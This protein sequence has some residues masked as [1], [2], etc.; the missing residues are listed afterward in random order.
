MKNTLLWR[1]LAAVFAFLLAAIIILT[2]LALDNAGTINNALNISTSVIVPSEGGEQT[3]TEYY[4]SE[5]G[6][7]NASN[8]A[9]LRAD[10]RA[11]NVAEMEEGAVLLKNDD[12][13]LPL[14]KGEIDNVSLFGRASVDPV[15][16]GNSAG[17]GGGE[18][19]WTDAL[20]EAGFTYN[21]TLAD[22]Y[23]NS[24]AKRERGTAG[25][26]YTIQIGE[27]PVSEYT[28]DVRASWEG[29]VAIVMISRAGGEDSELIMEMTDYSGRDAGKSQLAL[30]E[31][32]KDM[33]QLLQT[34]KQE[35]RISKIV[36]LI[37]SGW[38][39]E[40][41]WL[42][43]YGVDAA[44]WIGQPGSYG[45]AG[46]ANILKGDANPSGRLAD[47]YAENSLSSPAVINAGS[48]GTGEWTNI[49]EYRTQ[50]TDAVNNESYYVVQAEGIYIGYKYYETRYEDQILGQ[51]NA[52]SSKGSSDGSAWNWADEV[53]FPFGYGLSYTTFEQTLDSVTVGE[54]TVTV[55]VTV[56][57][58]GDVAGKSVVQVYAQ[59]PY[60][61]YEKQ[62][63]VEK[64]AIQLVA[65]DKTDLLQPDAEQQLSIEVEKYL[66]ASYD[67]TLEKGYIMSEGDY[68]ISVGD[69]S[70]DA[71][72]NVLAKKGADGMVATGGAA[73]SGNAEKVYQWH[74][75]FDGDKYDY[76]DILKEDDVTAGEYAADK[77]ALVT[78]RFDDADINHWIEDT[79]TYLSRSDWDAT[80]PEHVEIALTDEM[81]YYL[82][83][84]FYQPEEGGR[85]VDDFIFGAENGLTFVMMKDVPYGDNVTWDRYLDQFTLAELAAQSTGINNYQP[86]ESVAKPGFLGG[87]GPDG[88]MSGTAVY[89][90]GS[91]GEN[92]GITFCAQVV[93][94]STFS[95]DL[96]QR[97]GELIGEV[98]LWTGKPLSFAPGGNIH[99]TPF[100]GR[101]F[102]YMSE[103]PT[104]CYYGNYYMAIGMESKGVLSGIKHVTGN[105]QEFRREGLSTFFNEQTIR[106]T[107]LR[108]EEGALRKGGAKCL[109]QSFNRIGV[110]FSSSSYALCTQIIIEEWGFRGMQETD[111]MSNGSYKQ[112]FEEML[113]AGTNTYCYDTSNLSGN[114]L[115]N[116]IIQNDD[117]EMVAKLRQSIKNVHYALSRS[118]LVNGLASDSVVVSVTPWWET[119]LYAAIGVLSVLTAASVVLFVLAERN[120]T[121][122]KGENSY[123]K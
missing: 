108:A 57:N 122:K 9:K 5:Y 50:F 1:G 41:G 120:I 115:V 97:R 15:Y 105:D 112:H 109:M 99:R 35:G 37:N 117:G 71:L 45:F 107:S 68:Y 40:A 14:S 106:E 26:P 24:S 58:T 87:D 77:G 85:S 27:T 90:D 34:E 98:G 4:K 22:F 29:D 70:H 23:G 12:G 95:P 17:S 8:L 16:R 54:D 6:E 81:L 116:A 110:T 63:L 78:N 66:L 60:G 86:A 53:V 59:T 103:D 80:W 31:D 33:M 43:D 111:A 100:G 47:I 121:R 2:L 74:E 113:M 67:Y 25:T 51:G 11:Q 36:V 89:A 118:V 101:N 13:A 119:A 38:A 39:M 82:N 94:A 61:E 76:A 18:L 44:L 91:Q 10:L 19:S 48:S 49:S 64:S 69:D 83:G 20:T 56:K 114:G 55:N 75:D 32:E 96:Q 104:L 21:Q 79:V 52:A 123:E 42:D 93:L 28:G 3:D 62:N 65:Y 84:D 73:T 102:E 88:G 72:N 46:V 92:V 7:K 30:G